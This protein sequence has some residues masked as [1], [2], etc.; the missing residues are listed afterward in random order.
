MSRRTLSSI[1]VVCVL[2]GLFLAAMIMPVPYVTMS[3]GPTVNVLGKTEGKQ[4][5][6]VQG[7]QTYPTQG[8]LRLTTVSVTSPGRSIHLWDAM[9]AWFD[10]TR[11]VYPKAVI[12]PPQQSVQDAQ[13]QSSVEMVS[14]QDTAVAAALTE[15]GY[16]LPLHVEILGVSPHSPADGKLKVRDQVVSV[17][18]TPI[19]SVQDVAK[20]VRANGTAKPARI[21]V[22]RNGEERTVT[23]RPAE[24]TSSPKRPRVGVS[25]GVGYQFPFNVQVRLNEQIG[26]PSA[27]LIFALSVYDTLTPGALTGGNE[28]AGTGTITEAGNVGPIGGIQ[29]KIVAAA[30]AGAKVFL[31]PPANC[32]SALGADVGKGR[33]RLVKAPTL[34]SAIGSL[35]AYAKNPSAN[36]PSCR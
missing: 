31:V 11:A 4:I 30:D 33:I 27:G 1:V 3:P 32:S 7:H 13:T 24:S 17:N 12:Y 16:K 8:Q 35:E 19:K 6:S 18:G 9:A 21:V 36:L 25:I 2:V 14:S 5:V 23:V 34:H 29:Q 10:G 26:G 28:V 22:R 20:L 15:L